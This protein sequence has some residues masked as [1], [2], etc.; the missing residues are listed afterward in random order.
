M[1]IEYIPVLFFMAA[2]AALAVFF[3]LC[4]VFLGPRR[5]SRVKSDPFEC[6]NPSQGLRKERFSIKFYV[7]AV[8]FIIFDIEAIF[9]FPWAS[10]FRELSQAP[11]WLMLFGLC[12]MGLFLG[13]LALALFYAWKK[14]ALEW[15]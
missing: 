1:L 3:T 11:G 12:E 14:G 15:D 2:G 4:S 13:I 9:F 5:P 6:G 7:I 8:L 10:I